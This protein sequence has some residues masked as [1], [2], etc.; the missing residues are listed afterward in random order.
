MHENVYLS[1]E[2]VPAGRAAVSVWDAGFLHGASAFTTMLVRSG[3][4]FR[5]DRHLPGFLDRPGDVNKK[6]KL[7][8]LSCGTEDPRFP[9]QLDLLDVLRQHGIKYVWYPS[10]GVHEWKVWRHALYEFAQKVFQPAS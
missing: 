5:L 7:L 6:L 3:R 2:I 8:F 10:P 9:G 1:G 4:V